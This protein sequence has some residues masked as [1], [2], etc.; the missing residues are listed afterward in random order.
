MFERGSESPTEKAEDACVRMDDPHD[1]E[2]IMNL[3]Y[4]IIIRNDPRRHY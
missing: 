4:P 2:E 3:D 1:K